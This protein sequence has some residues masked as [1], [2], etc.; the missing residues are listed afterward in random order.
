VG[1][2]FSGRRS[3]RGPGSSS[4]SPGVCFGGQKASRRAKRRSS[5][6][7]RRSPVEQ[8]A[9]AGEGRGGGAVP[10]WGRA[11]GGAGTQRRWLGRPESEGWRRTVGRREER[12]GGGCRRQTRADGRR[13]A[14]AGGRGRDR[15]GGRPGKKGN[16]CSSSC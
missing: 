8:A 1:V 11:G 7:G 13:L 15:A 16:S 5:T 14:E 10:T 6:V 12:A 4:R 2:R 9:P 3:C